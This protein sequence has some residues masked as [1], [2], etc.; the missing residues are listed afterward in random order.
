MHR[1]SSVVRKF[2]EAVAAGAYPPAPNVADMDVAA[3]GVLD[4][5]REWEARAHEQM[6]VRAST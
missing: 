5:Q 3:F 2:D 6:C 4:D 1:L